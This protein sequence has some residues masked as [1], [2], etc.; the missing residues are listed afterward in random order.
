MLYTRGRKGKPLRIFF[1]INKK[2]KKH[3]GVF[4]FFA[5]SLSKV[6]FLMRREKIVV[7]LRAGV[8]G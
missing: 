1:I 4:F 8:A 2:Q 5:S 7:A 3:R 6:H